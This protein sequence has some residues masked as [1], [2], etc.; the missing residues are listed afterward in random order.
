MLNL[1]V[2]NQISDFHISNEK[3]MN[4]FF[5]HLNRIQYKQ[6]WEDKEIEDL[7]TLHKEVKLTGV[8]SGI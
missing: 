6:F 2:G 7:R 3:E 8:K 4:D 1:N 5:A